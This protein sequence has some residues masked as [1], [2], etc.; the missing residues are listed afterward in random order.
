M[1]MG[2]SKPRPSSAIPGISGNMGAA[3]SVKN[4]QILLMI[5]VA[6]IFLSMETM[7]LKA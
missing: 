3:S 4:Y 2:I 1:G 7:R 6:H 5:L